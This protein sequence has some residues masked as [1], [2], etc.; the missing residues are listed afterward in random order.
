MN[1]LV[2]PVLYS[3]SYSVCDYYL[4][5]P[6]GYLNRFV[7]TDGDLVNRHLNTMEQ[8]KQRKKTFE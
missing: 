7:A 4:E 8:S 1:V 5:Q 3:V 6:T 2:E